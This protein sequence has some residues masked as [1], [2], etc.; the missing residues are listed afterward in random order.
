[1]T[2]ARV[3]LDTNILVSGVVFAGNERKLLDA[4]VDGKLAMVLSADV[5]DEANTVLERKFSK[6]A[7]LFPLFLRL[8]KHE[9]IPKKAYKSSEKLYAELIGDEA[10]VPI[11]A[12]AAVS[13]ADYLVTGDK[14]LLALGQVESTEIIQTW[15]LLKRLGI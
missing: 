1:M 8:V 5:V 9:K 3:F 6:H 13:K 10:D 12:A 14:E 4:I 2:R 15:K 11:L 7:V